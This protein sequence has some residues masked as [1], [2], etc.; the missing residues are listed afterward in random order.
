MSEISALALGLL[1]FQLPAVAILLSRLLRGPLRHPSLQPQGAS[2]EWLGTV[3][4]V[5]PTLNEVQRLTPCLQGLTR[6]GYEVREIT[7]VDSRSQDGTPDLVKRFQQHDPRLRLL[8]DDPLPPGWVG[9]PWA[10][11]T[12]VFKQFPPESV[13]FR[14]RCRYPAS[15]GVGGQPSDHCTGGG[16]RFDFPLSTVYSQDPWRTLVTAGA[17]HH[18]G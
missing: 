12:G 6:Q 1:L 8:T 10:L 3:S 7:V 17:A 13:D 11:H 16:I 14:D 18:P 9:R 5:I 4:V 15:T 2:P